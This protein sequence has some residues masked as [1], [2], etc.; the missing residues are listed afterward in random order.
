VAYLF[1]IDD[2]YLQSLRTTTYASNPTLPDPDL[3]RGQISDAT[4][5][6]EQCFQVRVA[7]FPCAGSYLIQSYRTILA[8]QCLANGLALLEQSICH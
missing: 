7:I 3:W 5:L 8:Y 4:S 6:A 2:Q 1:K